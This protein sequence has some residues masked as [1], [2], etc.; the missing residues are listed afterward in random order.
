MNIPEINITD[1]V[2]IEN[3]LLP[4]ISK[5]KLIA[6]LTNPFPAADTLIRRRE[7]GEHA[8]PAIYVSNSQYF[9]LEPN[10]DLLN[11]SFFTVNEYEV[12]QHKGGLDEF[13][14]KYGL[15]VYSDIRT[16]GRLEKQKVDVMKALNSSPGIRI[17]SVTDKWDDIWLEWSLREVDS[18]YLMYPFTA[19]RVN[20]IIKFTEEC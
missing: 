4:V 10:S 1:P 19:F 14:A 20:G 3:A 13:T 5:L 12:T 6:W 9:P 17:E 18:Q 8:F 16:A 2:L 7:S 11:Y 15:I